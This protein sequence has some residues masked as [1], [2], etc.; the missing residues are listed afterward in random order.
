R[1]QPYLQQLKAD[2]G[3]TYRELKAAKVQLLLVA[4]P[5]PWDLGPSTNL[6]AT[7]DVHNLERE[8]WMQPPYYAGPPLE[9]KPLVSDYLSVEHALVTALR[10]TG[11]PVL[12]LWPILRSVEK[13]TPGVLYPTEDLHF[14]GEGRKIVGAA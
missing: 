9:P 4:M 14:S 12:D 7:E 11:A 3:A 10:E 5:F 2:L 8:T 13:Q 1:A 6:F